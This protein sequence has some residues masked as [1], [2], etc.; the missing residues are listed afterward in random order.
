MSHLEPQDSVMYVATGKKLGE[1][2]LP[3]PQR[4]HTAMAARIGAVKVQ[5]V[6][7]GEL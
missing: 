1:V 7:K 2:F 4:H 5:G 3:A 6:R